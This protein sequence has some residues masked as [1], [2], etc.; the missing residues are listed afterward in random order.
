M[1]PTAWAGLPVGVRTLKRLVPNS[2]TLPL[3][4]TCNSL[5]ERLEDLILG[6]NTNFFNTYD[7]HK[8]A[9]QL[10]TIINA[11]ISAPNE[12]LVSQPSTSLFASL[13]QYSP[14][15]IPSAHELQD[16]E[17]ASQ[18]ALMRASGFPVVVLYASHPL[19]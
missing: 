11:M 3:R 15:L 17:S 1:K 8:H 14:T 12:F 4:V 18:H 5:P 2:I 6:S 16:A 19:Y 7:R 10:P 9:T 13:A